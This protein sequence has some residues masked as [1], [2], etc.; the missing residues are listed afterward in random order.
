MESVY[1][2]LALTI[3]VWLV[4]PAK[5]PQ[6]QQPIPLTPQSS[7]KKKP[8]LIK[9]NLPKTQIPQI[10]YTTYIKSTNWSKNTARLVTLI[11]DKHSCRMCGD[12]YNVEVHH[13]TYKNLGTEKLNQVVTL[14][15]DCHSY[16]HKIAGKGAGYYPPLLK[17][18]G[19][20]CLK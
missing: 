1:G 18:Q 17:P 2:L 16:T 15:K 3:M 8:K 7:R 5:T 20:K 12:A 19:Y 10:D 6:P 11:N 4:S 13:I 9:W 14:C